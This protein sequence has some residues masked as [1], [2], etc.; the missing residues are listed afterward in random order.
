MLVYIR[1]AKKEDLDQI[2]IIIDEAKKLLK[3]D[4][5]PQWQSGSP[6]RE[7]LAE[8]IAKERAY[9]LVAEIGR[10]HV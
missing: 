6:N 9:C 7:M 10:A 2:M 1:L 3:K 4:G 8:D 5:I